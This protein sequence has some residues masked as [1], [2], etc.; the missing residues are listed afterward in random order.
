MTA[1]RV[2]PDP[3]PTRAR[4]GKAKGKAHP[5]RRPLTRN[6]FIDGVG[7]GPDWGNAGDYPEDWTGGKDRPHLFEE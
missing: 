6:V 2:D 4:K 1:E 5:Q 3:V 7:Y